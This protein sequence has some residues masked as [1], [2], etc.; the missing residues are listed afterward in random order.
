VTKPQPGIAAVLAIVTIVAAG[1]TSGPDPIASF[2][3]ASG[4]QYFVRPVE[5]EGPAGTA[6]LDF[7][8]KTD[9]RPVQVNFSI[10]LD[11]AK[12]LESAYLEGADAAR[13]EL[14]EIERFVVRVDHARFGSLLDRSDFDALRATPGGT[15]LIISGTAESRFVAEAAYQERM[16]MLNLMLF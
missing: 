8:V 12:S 2:V 5:L 9:S 7:T 1:C 3:T 14:R 15:S 10:P 11:T 13:Y 16:E 6:E 4:T